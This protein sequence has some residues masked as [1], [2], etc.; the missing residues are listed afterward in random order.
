METYHGHVETPRDAVILLEACRLGILFRVQRRLSKKEKQT[1]RSG[2][3]FVWDEGEADI[4]RWTDENKRCR[5]SATNQRGYDKTTGS[6]RG[7]DEDQHRRGDTRQ[8][9]KAGGL[10]KLSLTT[11]T[12]NGQYLHLVSY[13]STQHGQH[14]LQQPANDPK[15]QN[16]I[17][18][19]DMSMYPEVQMDKAGTLLATTC[20]PIQGP[21]YAAPQYDPQLP[22]INGQ[23]GYS[24]TPS[25][26]TNCSDK[27]YVS[28]YP[29]VD[30]PQS[31]FGAYL[32]DMALTCYTETHNC[33]GLGF[34]SALAAEYHNPHLLHGDS[35]LAVR[36]KTFEVSEGYF[37][38]IAQSNIGGDPWLSSSHA[39]QVALPSPDP[40]FN[41]F[42]G[43]SD[44][45]S[46]SW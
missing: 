18:N 22:A 17:D 39:Y 13:Y 34:C 41:S 44:D 14:E 12:S 32:Y 43:L 29:P 30:P 37:K 9:V 40:S 25:C 27:R 4:T 10:V 19:M 16:V 5:R 7:R 1:I 42:L 35:N 20:A 38:P 45:W 6:G 31:P 26:S 33:E 46:I 3:I 36:G 2:S 23:L 11:T 24:Y 8:L 15:M 28:P 21:P